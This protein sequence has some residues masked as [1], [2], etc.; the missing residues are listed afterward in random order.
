MKGQKQNKGGI[1]TKEN[2]NKRNGK[3][4]QKHQTRKQKTTG[5]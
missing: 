3:Q 5:N 2:E 1:E 4:K